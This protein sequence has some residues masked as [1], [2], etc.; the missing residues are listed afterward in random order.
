MEASNL[1]ELRILNDRGVDAFRNYLADSAALGSPEPRHLLND[2]H[3]SKPF[4]PT[5]Y[6]QRSKEFNNKSELAEYLTETFD[7]AG[8]TRQ[9]SVRNRIS[10]HQLFYSILINSVQYLMTESE[11]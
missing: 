4:I 7:R 1:V 9:V 10:G 5:V 3:F 6:L 11:M 8:L 2:N